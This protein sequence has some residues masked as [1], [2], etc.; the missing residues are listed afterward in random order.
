ME[1]SVQKDMKAITESQDVQVE[2]FS[3]CR[4]KI[5]GSARR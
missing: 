1:A 4:Q 3:F 2:A 5:Q